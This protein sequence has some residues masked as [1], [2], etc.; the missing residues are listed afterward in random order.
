MTPA[1]EFARVA[2]AEHRIEE[3]FDRGKG[4]AGMGDYQVRN[5]VGWH[6]HQTLSL[7]AS[8]FL[9]VETRRAEKKTPAITFNQVRVAVA[10][11]I[12]G[13][14]ECDS[15]RVVS[16][17]ITKRL[18]RNQHAKLYHWRNHKRLPPNNLNRRKI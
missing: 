2:K 14:Y 6:H 1:T 3:C 13:V 5:W 18:I 7:V 16:A 17:R 4:E 10:S 12:R 9:N 15:P 11:I 8:W